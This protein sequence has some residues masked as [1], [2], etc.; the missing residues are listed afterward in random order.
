MR[1]TECTLHTTNLQ[2]QIVNVGIGRKVKVVKMV[3]FDER[4][5]EKI[6]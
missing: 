5:N 1:E 4:K 2:R 6:I 3:F